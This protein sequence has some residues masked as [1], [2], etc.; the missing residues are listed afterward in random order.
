MDPGARLHRRGGPV[1][2]A[3]LL[4]DFFDF[5]RVDL[6]LAERTTKDYGRKMRR[7]LAAVNKPARDVTAI[8]NSALATIFACRDF[9]T[10][11]DKF[12]RNRYSAI[13]QAQRLLGYSHNTRA[14]IL[15]TR[16]F[17]FTRSK[18]CGGKCLKCVRKQMTTPLV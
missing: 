16:V 2:A 5:C 12:P 8:F 3:S 11:M 17:L 15:N 10:A 18:K 13:E 4:Q 7:F 6:G 9:M 1:D 14:V